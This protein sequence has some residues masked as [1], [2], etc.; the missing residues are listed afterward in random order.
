[1]EGNSTAAAAAA[2]VDLVAAQPGVSLTEPEKMLLDKFRQQDVAEK[3]KAP[4]TANKGKGRSRKKGRSEGTIFQKAVRTQPGIGEMMSEIDKSENQQKK[5]EQWKRELTND[6]K[7]MKF[8]RC[9][10][11]GKVVNKS[12][13]AA[14]NSYCPAVL[15]MVK[16]QKEQEE[17]EETF[18]CPYCHV[19]GWK[20]RSLTT[21]KGRCTYNPNSLMA[22]TGFA[23]VIPD[24]SIG[25]AAAASAAAAPAPTSTSA[26]VAPA[27][28]PVPAPS[29]PL[30]KEQQGKV[31]YEAAIASA[32]AMGAAV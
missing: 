29:K 23:A 9:A 30:S 1:L 15:A 22:K 19:P 8:V 24:N 21:H 2:V 32:A 3:R 6:T 5:Y 16:Q 10:G 18:V 14:H 31:A 25:V 7:M 17:E 11:C 13:I 27:A 28:A 20:E 12:S 26:A 4:E